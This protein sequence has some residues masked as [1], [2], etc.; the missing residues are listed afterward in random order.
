LFFNNLLK[1]YG[2]DPHTALSGFENSHL[3]T[4]VLRFSKSLCLA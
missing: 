4:Y 3:L 2:S 1:D